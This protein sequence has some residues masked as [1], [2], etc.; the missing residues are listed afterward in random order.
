[1]SSTYPP[2]SLGMQDA[3]VKAHVAILVK[4][5]R[6]LMNFSLHGQP[7]W[8]G[9][10]G[11]GYPLGKWKGVIP[12]DAAEKRVIGL[13]DWWIWEPKN[14]FLLVNPEHYSPSI[15][16][17]DI[18]LVHIRGTPPNSNR[19]IHYRTVPPDLFSDFTLKGVKPWFWR[20]LQDS[21]QH[22]AALFLCPHLTFVRYTEHQLPTQCTQCPALGIS[23][24]LRPAEFK[25]PSP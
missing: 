9:R 11:E 18:Q 22:V 6:R 2:I 10:L 24:T 14:T 15:L 16:G 4:T 5:D 23:S 19:L 17:A 25:C 20:G 7:L 21:L 13:C 1:M 12:G 8:R 3:C